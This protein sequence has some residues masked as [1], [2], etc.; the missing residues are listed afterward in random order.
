MRAVSSKDDVLRTYANHRRVKTP[1]LTALRNSGS[2]EASSD[3][4]AKTRRQSKLLSIHNGEPTVAPKPSKASKR[5]GEQKA[6]QAKRAQAA[7]A[8]GNRPTCRGIPPIG[9][10]TESPAKLGPE[11]AR[12]SQQAKPK[13]SQ[14]ESKQSRAKQRSSQA[15]RSHRP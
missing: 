10:Q 4:V 15:T 7:E 1:P 11:H 8:G 9:E 12:A 6:K 3:E 14:A 5:H 13:A 2:R